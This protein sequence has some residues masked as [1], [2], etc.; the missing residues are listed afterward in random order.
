MKE[1]ECKSNSRG[2]TVVNRIRPTDSRL[3]TNPTYQPVAWY[4]LPKQSIRTIKQSGRWEKGKHWGVA[5]SQ[6]AK[7]CIFHPFSQPLSNYWQF[8]VFTLLFMSAM[9]SFSSFSSVKNLSRLI[10]PS[11]PLY[12]SRSGYSSFA[13]LYAGIVSLSYGKY[14][15]ALSAAWLALGVSSYF[16]FSKCSVKALSLEH[17]VLRASGSLTMN[18][19]S[20]V[21]LAS[22]PSLQIAESNCSFTS[23]KKHPSLYC[24]L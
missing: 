2:K 19:Y 18:G 11:L 6:C 21:P 15:Y 5:Q 9:N 24:S 22:P 23:M 17:N 1:L 8:C 20:E 7:E 12:L 3:A 10:F 4:Q 16:T 13:S 14:S